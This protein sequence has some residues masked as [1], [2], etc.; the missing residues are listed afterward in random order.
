MIERERP[1]FDEEL[2]ERSRRN[3]L[4]L[5]ILRR[6]GP[7]SRTEISKVSGI[8]PVTISHYLDKLMVQNI[9]RERQH[10]TSSGGRPPMLLN[11]NPEAGFTLGIG[12]NLF[13]SMGVIID[14]EGNVVYKY[15]RDKP[16]TTP[17]E[18]IETIVAIIEELLKS[19][20]QITDKIKGI[21]VGLGGIIDSNKGIIRWPQKDGNTFFYSYISMPIK[22]YLEEKF[23]LPVYIGNDANLACFAEYWLSLDPE[24]KDVVYLFSGVG[25]GIMINGE[26]YTGFDGCAGELFINKPHNESVPYLGDYSFF[27][28]W[29][30]DLSLL[31]IAKELTAKNRDVDIHTLDDVFSAAKEVPAVKELVLESAR[32]LGI[33][34]SLL[35]NILNPQVV[36][37]GGGLEKG[38]FEFVEN[39]YQ[40]IKKHA[41]EEMTNNLKVIP[42]SLGS[43]ASALGAA[44]LVVRNIFTYI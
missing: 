25:C 1:I 35:V 21:G 36:I 40:H 33:K 23:N 32:A 18:I 27:G 30:H 4:I 43:Q 7:L 37:I 17:N 19:A 3:F 34:I 5:E 16:A 9:V 42:S 6:R 8:N 31:D 11:I 10:D 20:G 12:M 29:S 13:D 26:L 39:I 2:T 38:G 15:K 28:Q 24:I 14:L 22:S 41:F 44:N